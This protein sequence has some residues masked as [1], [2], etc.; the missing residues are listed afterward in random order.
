MHL[1]IRGVVSSAVVPFDM[2]RRRRRR[3][4]VPIRKK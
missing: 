1:F 3:A 2:R 4:D